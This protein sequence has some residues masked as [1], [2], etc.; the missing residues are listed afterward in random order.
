MS[1]WKHRDSSGW[2][3]I[4]DS[5]TTSLSQASP[6]DSGSSDIGSGGSPTSPLAFRSV[7][8]RKSTPAAKAGGRVIADAS[9]AT[10]LLYADAASPSPQSAR[11]RDALHTQGTGLWVTRLSLALFVVGIIAALAASGALIYRRQVETLAAAEAARL[12][13]EAAAAAAARALDAER[14]AHSP[15]GTLVAF[16]GGLVVGIVAD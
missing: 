10:Q 8:G 15:F 14:A 1:I 6:A 5:P 13:A 16:L 9:E 2:A 11:R 12:A 7:A 3:N 4:A